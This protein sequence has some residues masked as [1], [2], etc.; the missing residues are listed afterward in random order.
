[1]LQETVHKVLMSQHT[2]FSKFLGYNV[3]LTSVKSQSR[4]YKGSTQL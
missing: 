2:Q 1:M 3:L 4:V